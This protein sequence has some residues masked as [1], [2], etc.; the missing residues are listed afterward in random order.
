MN[1]DRIIWTPQGF[2]VPAH[3]AETIRNAPNP[4]PAYS[5]PDDVM[6]AGTIGDYFGTPI[7]IMQPPVPQR[8]R[9]WA[10]AWQRLTRRGRNGS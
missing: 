10:R 8:P 1:D 6:H 2:Y 7:Y 3:L 4:T 9:W 5:R